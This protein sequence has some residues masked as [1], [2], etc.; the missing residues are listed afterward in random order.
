MHNFGENMEGGV[1]I[2]ERR[3]FY[4]KSC[5]NYMYSIALPSLCPCPLHCLYLYVYLVCTYT[6]LSHLFLLPIQRIHLFWIVRL[7]ICFLLNRFNELPL[8]RPTHTHMLN[9]IQ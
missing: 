8:L 7:F 9:G 3:H 5:L 4:I 2:E 1:V 6:P